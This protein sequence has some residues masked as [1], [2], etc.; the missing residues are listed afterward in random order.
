MD[1]DPDP[2]FR[3]Q[4]INKKQKQNKPQRAT[5]FCVRNDKNGF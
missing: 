5:S 3:K 1:T 4:K 2:R